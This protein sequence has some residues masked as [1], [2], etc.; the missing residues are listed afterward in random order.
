MAD[1]VGADDRLVA[2]PEKE[3]VHYFVW[4][5]REMQRL[6]QLPCVGCEAP[7]RAGR[8]RPIEALMEKADADV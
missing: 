5:C 2:C 6:G 7:E 8:M 1:A 4:H 3:G